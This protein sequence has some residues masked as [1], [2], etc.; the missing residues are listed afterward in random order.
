MFTHSVVIASR[1]VNPEKKLVRKFSRIARE[2]GLRF[3]KDRDG[4][5]RFE[6]NAAVEKD[7]AV[8]KCSWCELDFMN[9]VPTQNGAWV[10]HVWKRC[11]RC[12][13]RLDGGADGNRILHS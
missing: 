7:L 13:Y 4:R 8:R 9:L 12:R 3:V 10:Y 6:S 5:L 11:P 2:H 1:V